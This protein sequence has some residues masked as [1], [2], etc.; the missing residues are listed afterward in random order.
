VGALLMR[1]LLIL[2]L[3]ALVLGPL[4]RPL[5]RHARF[6][7]PAIIG[8]I[9]GLAL[10][11]FLATRA[12]LPPLFAALLVLVVAGALAM[13]LGEACKNYID[14]IFGPRK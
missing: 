11:C 4:R 1:S 9:L 5:L 2:L 10:G 14:R 8:G 3:L 12:G 7:V 6:T 13:H